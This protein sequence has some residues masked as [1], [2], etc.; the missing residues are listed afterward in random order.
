M[1]PLCVSPDDG[2]LRQFTTLRF[3]DAPPKDRAVAIAAAERRGISVRKWFREAIEQR[4]DRDLSDTPNDCR[5]N[6]YVYVIG[7]LDGT[8]VKV[9]SSRRPRQRLDLLR[10]LLNEPLGL[11]FVQG[12]E[13]FVMVEKRAHS[14]LAAHA[15]GGEWFRTSA[16]AAAKAI[17]AA[18]WAVKY[19]LR[20]TPHQPAALLPS[21]HEE[22]RPVN[23][24]A[25]ARE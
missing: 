22:P 24:E 19:E 12:A 2:R 20:S 18:D 5:V 1:L 8:R 15:L 14:L 17:K 21:R 3:R 16:E 10:C 11:F 13:M 23:G 7:P 4:I 25:T 6:G 9:G